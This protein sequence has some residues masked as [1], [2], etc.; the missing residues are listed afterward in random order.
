MWR[1]SA[2]PLAL[3]IFGLASLLR[4]QS[5]STPRLPDGAMKAKVTTACTECHNAQIVM[6]QRLNKAAWAKEVDKMSKWGA[7]VEPADRDGFIEYLS[8]NFPPEKDP[9]IA[10][11][12]KK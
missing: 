1:L 10:P 7:L 5:N 6:Q 12:M 4:A 9:Y 3:I 2:T 8:S 11:R